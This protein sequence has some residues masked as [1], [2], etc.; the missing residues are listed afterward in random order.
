MQGR[1]EVKG[2]WLWADSARS[3]ALGKQ[4]FKIR[5]LVLGEAENSGVLCGEA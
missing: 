3:C 4:L 5:P 1:K 2:V